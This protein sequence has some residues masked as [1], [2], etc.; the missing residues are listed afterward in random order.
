MFFSGVVDALWGVPCITA[1]VIS[2]HD[3]ILKKKKKKESSIP[4]RIYFALFSIF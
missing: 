3:G 1:T 2:M 4:Q